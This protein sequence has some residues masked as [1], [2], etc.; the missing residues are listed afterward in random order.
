METSSCDKGNITDTYQDTLTELVDVEDKI[1]P[2]EF[3]DIGEYQEGIT[4]EELG[5]TEEDHQELN[6]LNHSND[7]DN[8]DYGYFD[9]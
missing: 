6:D 1:E 2:V 4:E 9:E 3:A 7:L 8:D 5:D